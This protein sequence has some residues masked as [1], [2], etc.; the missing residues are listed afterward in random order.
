MD[1]Q[2]FQILFYNA[3]YNRSVINGDYSFENASVL[4]TIV[5]KIIPML[6]KKLMRGFSLTSMYDQLPKIIT[7]LRIFMEIY[8]QHSN[9]KY[10]SEQTV[11]RT[12]TT[13]NQK[14]KSYRR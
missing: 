9:L 5:D 3:F 10:G 13:E 8:M 2:Y 4:T 7:Y 12:I 14:M 11:L 1:P 6:I